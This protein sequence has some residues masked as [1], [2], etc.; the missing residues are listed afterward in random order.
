MDLLE[1]SVQGPSQKKLE[2]GNN[3]HSLLFLG[4]TPSQTPNAFNKCKMKQMHSKQ[5]GNRLDTT[6]LLFMS[7]GIRSNYKY[8]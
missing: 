8:H 1:A 6:F 4:G 2:A 7:L 5:L 3:L